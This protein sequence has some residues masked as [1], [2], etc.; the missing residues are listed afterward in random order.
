M[1]SADVNQ[2]CQTLL[3]LRLVDQRQMD[4]CLVGPAAGSVEVFLQSL[5]RKGLITSYQ[6]SQLKKGGE[7]SG[8]VLGHYALLYH[9]ASGSF[10]RVF[11]A[12]DLN[13]GQML[14]LKV[15]R[16]R[17]AK[18]PK[19]I[20]EFK[21]EAELGKTLKHDNIVPIYEVG[22]DQGEYYLSMEFVEGGNLRDFVNIRKKL[23]VAEATKA[24]FEMANALQYAL[25]RGLTHRDLKLTNVL[26]S[27]RGVAKLVDFGLAGL[28]P[29]A[30]NDANVSE[31]AQRAIEYATLEKNT[32]VSRN[33]PRS[34]LYFLGGIFYELLTGVPP[35]PRT[36]SAEERG[37]FHRYANVKPVR[38]H[39]PSLPLGVAAVIEKL[40]HI[41]P[42]VRY[43]SA[44][45][46]V[47]DLRYLMDDYDTIPP[48]AAKTS[49][50]TAS[51]TGGALEAL[52]AEAPVA[53]VNNAPMVLCVEVRMK[54]QDV[55][56][57]YLTKHG[58]RVLMF[59]DMQRAVSRVL[60]S[61]P[62]AA[63]VI[64]G[65]GI[66]DDALLGFQTLCK[67]APPDSVTCL[68]MVSEKQ[69]DVYDAASKCTTKSCRVLRQ[70]LTLR[71]LHHEIRAGLIRTGHWESTATQ[72]AE[73]SE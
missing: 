22:Q 7:S 27:T 18:N 26:M 69:A 64:M 20:A 9:N 8:L 62:P 67:K 24:T 51:T 5:E 47:S 1:A 14:G 10:A 49:T 3:K 59:S 72:S 70:P 41:N 2:I 73:A 44:A 29:G 19:S 35:L 30:Q 46:A 68:L 63:I 60:N 56:R 57:A 61:N 36:R 4:D 53:P 37:E 50:V 58:Y 65:D 55:L 39:D 6:S 15:L 52:V 33:D 38:E 28:D 23:S 66:G 42:K 11:R 12:K 25:E 54:H 17:Y 43:Q 40:M 45:E 71:D 13:T 48:L 21:R 34:D 32:G 31:S 16:S